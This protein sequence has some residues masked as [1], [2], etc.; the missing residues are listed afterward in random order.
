VGPA[1]AL[2]EQSR[3]WHVCELLEAVP[4]WLCEITE[5]QC[6]TTLGEYQCRFNAEAGIN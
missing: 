3:A 6:Q 1:P 5:E 2:L 4:E